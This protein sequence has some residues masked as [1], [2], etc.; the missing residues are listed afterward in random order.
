MMPTTARLNPRARTGSTTVVPDQ[1]SPAMMA[2]GCLAWTL[3]IIMIAAIAGGVVASVL[4]AVLI[5]AVRGDEDDEDDDYDDFYDDDEEEENFLD[6]LD[7][8]RQ[9]APLRRSSTATGSIEHPFPPRPD[10]LGGLLHRKATPR[11]AAPRAG[12]QSERPEAHR[13]VPSPPPSTKTAG[14]KKA[15]KRRWL[16]QKRQREPRFERRKSTLT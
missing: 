7:R 10:P 11:K 16:L 5:R 4:L 1:P 13:A 2:E 14:K 6:R 15:A 12:L 8:T 9:A 3:S